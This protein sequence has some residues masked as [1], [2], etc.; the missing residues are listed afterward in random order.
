[1]LGTSKH[2]TTVDIVKYSRSMER[3]VDGDIV[4]FR[5]CSLPG[6]QESASMYPALNQDSLSGFLSNV[7]LIILIKDK[8]Y[9]EGENKD[10]VCG[11]LRTKGL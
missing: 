2:L 4:Y 7:K 9:Q 5:H 3:D 8:W 10:D 11:L 1:M 6:A